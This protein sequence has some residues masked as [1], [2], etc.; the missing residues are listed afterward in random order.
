MSSSPETPDA[1]LLREERDI[2]ARLS[3]EPFDFEAAQAI[4]NIYRAASAVR[5]RAEREL[6]NDCNLTWGGFTML[7]V[8]WVWGTMDSSSL[9]AEC[10]VAKGTMTGM[11]TTLEK[12]GLVER[13]R[14][15][16][17]RRRVEVALTDEGS[18]LIAEL[19]PRFNAL[20]VGLVAGLDAD[21]QQALA[22]LLRRI[23]HNA[24]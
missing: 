13:T 20:E 8:L 11:V 12:R 5:V 7:W 18:A 23:I 6:L 3:G 4:Q 16:D 19:Y 2:R 1:D 14:D 15:N 22:A 17:D 24:G 9:A 21:D 10:G